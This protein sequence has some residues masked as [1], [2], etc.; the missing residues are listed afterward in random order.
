MALMQADDCVERDVRERLFSSV[1]SGNRTSTTVRHGMH[2]E[3]RGWSFNTFDNVFGEWPVVPLDHAILQSV[4]SL[5]PKKS[6]AGSTSDREEW[7]S[8][9]GM[10]LHQVRRLEIGE[11][12][13]MLSKFC[14]FEDFATQA[15]QFHEPS[16][17]T[18]CNR[19]TRLCLYECFAVCKVQPPTKRRPGFCPKFAVCVTTAAWTKKGQLRLSTSYMKDDEDWSV[20]TQATSARVADYLSAA[21]PQSPDQ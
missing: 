15:Q 8:T 16:G 10:Q 2:T 6:G 17:A 19:G 21:Y 4:Q 13:D 3:L 18:V 14:H 9:P 20:F 1:V 7:M 11:Q 5:T 12:D